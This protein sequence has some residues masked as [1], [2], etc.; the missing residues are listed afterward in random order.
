LHL[1]NEEVHEYFNLDSIKDYAAH[2]SLDLGLQVLQDCADSK[3]DKAEER[4]RG[5]GPEDF[6]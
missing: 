3:R 1:T 4:G 5:L 6:R 2:Y